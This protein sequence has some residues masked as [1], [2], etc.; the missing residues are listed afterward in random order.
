MNKT[1]SMMNIVA[2]QEIVDSLPNFTFDGKFY[3][4]VIKDTDPGLGGQ[5]LHVFDATSGAELPVPDE[6][7]F[8][9]DVLDFIDDF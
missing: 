1:I 6:E 9:D 8:P 4:W 2:L 3:V 7:D 5:D